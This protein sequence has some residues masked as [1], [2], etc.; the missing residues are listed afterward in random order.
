M[1]SFVLYRYKKLEDG[2]YDALV[3]AQAGVVR[4]GWHDRISQ[5]RLVSSHFTLIIL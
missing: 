2:L 3:L 1:T 5:A 4:L